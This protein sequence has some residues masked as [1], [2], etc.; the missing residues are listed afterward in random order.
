MEHGLDEPADLLSAEL[1]VVCGAL[2]ARFESK[3]KPEL[4]SGY[5]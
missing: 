5:Q 3:K 2:I 4:T 1:R